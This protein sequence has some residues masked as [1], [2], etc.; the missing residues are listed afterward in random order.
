MP[1]QGLLN[2]CL[3]ILLV[4]T[5]L[6]MG[7][8]TEAPGPARLLVEGAGQLLVSAGIG[9]FCGLL[10]ARLFKLV[11]HTRLYPIHQTALVMLFGYLSY[12]IAEGVGVSGI[13]TLFLAAVTQAHY[14]WASLS[15]SAQLATRISFV[16]IS[17]IAEVRRRDLGRNWNSRSTGLSRAPSFV[18]PRTLIPY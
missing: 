2:D 12:C 9:V 16:A 1:P 18:P 7:E 8:A 14:V 13:L 3:S 6:K 15:K 17:D 10:N 4:R 11:P 5:L